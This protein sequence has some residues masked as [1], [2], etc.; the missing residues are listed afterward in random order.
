[1]SLESASFD[2]AL[3]L[4]ATKRYDEALAVLD[5]FAQGRPKVAGIDV[6]RARLLFDKGEQDNALA[7]LTEAMER[8]PSLEMHPAHRWAAR[9]VLAHCYG[10]LLM[11]QGRN[12]DALP[13]LDEAARRNGLASG[14]WTALVHL[15]LAYFRLGDYAT[16]A[17]YWYT[18]LFR[19]PDLGAHDILMLV[20]HYI[21]DAE[22][23]GLAVEP[24]MRVCLARLAI[25]N[26]DLL[27]MADHEADTYAAQQVA[28]VLAR[29]PEQPQARR[30]RASLRWRGGDRA[31]AIDDMAAYLQ[32]YPEPRSQVRLLEW[33]HDA[34]EP[35]PWQ[36]FSL[37]TSVGDGHDCYFAGLALRAFM[38]RVPESAPALAPHLRQVW[39]AGLARFEHYFATGE[40]GHGDADTRLYSELCDQLAQLLVDPG[41]R[42]RRIDLHRRGVVVCDFIGHWLDIIACHAAGGEPQQVVEVSGEVLNHYALDEHARDV[43]WVFSHLIAAW[44]AI[45]GPEAVASARAAMA[46]MEARLDALPVEERS[47]AAQS[48]AQARA[49]LAGLLA[50]AAPGMS[51]RDKALALDEIEAHQ[52]RALQLEDA[53]CLAAFAAVWRQLGDLDR[54]LPLLDRAMAMVTGKAE[55]EAPL[56]V[57]RGALK[58][59]AGQHAEALEDFEVAFALQDDWAHEVWLQ[60]AQA[61]VA[62][63]RREVALRYFRKAKESGAAQGRSR[64]LYR[65]V[66]QGLKGLRPAW[67]V[68]GV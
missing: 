52:Q 35:Q 27:E 36:N 12:D 37:D 22:D 18:L 2:R 8:L 60:A 34:G 31:G 7:S 30:A 1:M 33:R 14:E 67:K 13:W 32:Q 66:E 17:H 11:N 55:T 40:G 9:G 64:T 50:D 28:L 48:M 26:A 57:Q 46:H 45:G 51:P 56:R 24:M 15:G 19:A 25:D 49:H 65:K 41:E 54:S 23:N 68:W 58:L 21:Q 59:E 44:R 53:A 39:E 62:L 6:L 3:E 42:A 5:A 20:S 38:Q 61:A 4:A 16:A 10:V 63:A 43:V 47:E 29:Q